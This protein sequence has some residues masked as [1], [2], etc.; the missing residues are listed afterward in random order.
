MGDS[1]SE[2]TTLGLGG[3]APSII[4]VLDSAELVA[5]VREAQE[6]MLPLLLI[7]GGSNLVISDAGFDGTVI[8]LQGRG[9]EIDGTTVTAQAGE[10]WDALVDHCV[11]NGLAGIEALSGIPGSAGATPIQ[12]VGAYGQEVADTIV[13]VRVLDRITDEILDLAPSDCGFGYRTSAFK[14][15]PRRWVVL[16]VAFEL[17]SAAESEPIAYTQLADALGVTEGDTAPLIEVREAVL[18]LRRS[19]GMVLD[20]SDLD[21]RSAGSFFTNPFVDAE[22]LKKIEQVTGSA[23]PAWPDGEHFKTSAAW[24]IEQAGFERGQG[25]PQGIAISSKH[26]LALTNRGNGT[27]EELLALAGQITAAVQEQ[28]GV[29]LER[30]PTLIGS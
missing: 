8:H 13:R 29:A 5:A 23:A 14:R 18:D 26:V 12:N 6:E 4:P 2:L 17:R 25:D 19:K 24:L 20:R 3:P 30:E 1:L 21:T 11:G 15:D 9:V 16:E 7:A 27:T 22:T 10:P 28:F